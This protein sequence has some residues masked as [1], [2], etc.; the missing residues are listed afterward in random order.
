[1]FVALAML[2]AAIGALALHIAARRSRDRLTRAEIGLR[3][4]L[5][6][7]ERIFLSPIAETALIITAPGASVA[8]LSPKASIIAVH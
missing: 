3:D 8:C 6:G 7:L 1:M 5:A 4:F 2:G